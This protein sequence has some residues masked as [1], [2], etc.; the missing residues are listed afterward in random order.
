MSEAFIK[1]NLKLIS[2]FHSYAGKHPE[3]FKQIPNKSTV[4]MTV[5]GDPYFNRLSRNMN[6]KGM[7]SKE[8]LVEA[9]KEGYR[10]TIQKA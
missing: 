10:W 8:K 7:S 4:V 3:L 9:R 5:K 6:R 2:Q 1:K